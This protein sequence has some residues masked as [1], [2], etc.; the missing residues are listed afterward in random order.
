MIEFPT[1]IGQKSITIDVTIIW[2]KKT[3]ATSISLAEG[4]YSHYCSLHHTPH[5]DIDIFPRFELIC[6]KLCM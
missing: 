5:S 6:L 1:I 3:F 2:N 4:F